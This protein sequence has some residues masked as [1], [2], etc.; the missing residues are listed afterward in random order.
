[1]AGQFGPQQG[2]HALGH[3]AASFQQHHCDLWL[4]HDV[5]PVK[6]RRG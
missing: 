3:P 6:L 1:M 5:D 4:R 2:S